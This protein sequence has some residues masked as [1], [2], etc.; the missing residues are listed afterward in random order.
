MIHASDHPEALSLMVRAYRKVSGRP[1]IDAED[2][3]LDLI[4]LLRDIQG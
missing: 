2:K 1:D 3:Q 4:A